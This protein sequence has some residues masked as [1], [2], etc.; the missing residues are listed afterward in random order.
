[1]KDKLEI[2]V[3]EDTKAHQESAQD[4]FKDHHLTL[5][6]HYEEGKQFLRTT[7]Y[8]ILLTDL[9]MPKGSSGTMSSEGMKYIFDLLPYGFPLVLLAAKREVPYLAIVTDINHHDHPMSASLDPIGG[10]YWCDNQ[11]EEL[12]FRINKSR[13]GVFHAPFL[14]DGRKDWKKV[15]EVLYH[16]RK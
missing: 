7:S 16:G 8:D 15:L 10:P 3:I 13:L 11:P 9:M 6:R 4:Q 14:D 12:V 2:L 1:M 5:A